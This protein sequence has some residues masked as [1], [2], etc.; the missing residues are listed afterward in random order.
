MFHGF[1][2]SFEGFP[3]Q[4]A[5]VFCKAILDNGGQIT[6]MLTKKTSHL[7]VNVEIHPGFQERRAKIQ[8]AW[9]VTES[10][11]FHSIK[12]GLVLP[13]FQFFPKRR[14]D[15]AAP[16]EG[17]E[18]QETDQLELNTFSND[19]ERL[20]EVIPELQQLLSGDSA[21]I[22]QVWGI[23]HVT[24]DTTTACFP[25][26][27]LLDGESPELIQNSSGIVKKNSTATLNTI[28]SKPLNKP[29]KRSKIKKISSR[30]QAIKNFRQSQ[31]NVISQVQDLEV[32]SQESDS[33]SSLSSEEAFIGVASNRKALFMISQSG[34]VWCKPDRVNQFPK[35]M[36]SSLFHAPVCMIDCGRAH[37]LAL[38]THGSVYSWGLGLSGQLGHADK[39]S[40]NTPERIRLVLGNIPVIQISAAGNS[41]AALTAIGGCYMWGS[42][43][44]GQLGLGHSTDVT[45][46]S[47][48]HFPSDCEQ[49]SS[50]ICG[51]A[52]SLAITND[53]KL[54]A[55]GDNQYGQLGIENLKQSV[56]NRPR[57]IPSLSGIVQAS[58]GFAH[59]L[60]VNHDGQVFSWG[61]GNSGVLG[62]GNFESYNKPKLIEFLSKSRVRVKSTQCSGKV[63]YCLS[64]TG[65]LFTFGELDST[66]DVLQISS[67]PKLTQDLVNVEFIYASDTQVNLIICD[68]KAMI[69]RHTIE[70]N[71]S[72]FKLVLEYFR[73]EFQ[74]Q[75]SRSFSQSSTWV[76]TMLEIKNGEGNSLLH[77]A[78]IHNRFEIVRILVQ[79]FG[80]GMLNELNNNSETA[81]YHCAL[82]HSD[83]SCEI[84]LDHPD[85]KIDLQ[86]NSGST[87]LHMAVENAGDSLSIVEMLVYQGADKYL[88]N[89]DG[90]TPLHLAVR[91]N[92]IHLARFLV[93][94]GASIME[95]NADGATPLDYCSWIERVVLKDLAEMN[96]VFISYAH[97]DMEFAVSVRKQL[98]NFCLRCWM[99]DWRLKPGDDW[100]SAIGEG[101][102]N[103][104]VVVFIASN[105]SVISDWC[106]KEL[107]LAVELSKKIVVIHQQDTFPQ[108]PMMD[109]LVKN[110][111]HQAKASDRFDCIN[112]SP[113]EFKNIMYQLARRLHNLLAGMKSS[114]NQK[115]KLK[116]SSSA[117]VVPPKAVGSRY[118]CFGYEECDSSFI[119]YLKSQLKFYRIDYHENM[120]SVDDEN[121]VSNAWVY[122][123]VVSRQIFSNPA[124]E[125]HLKWI[126]QANV[127]LMILYYDADSDYM[128]LFPT[129]M[130]SNSQISKLSKLFSF[131][132]SDAPWMKQLIYT[133]NLLEKQALLSY[134]IDALMEKVNK[135]RK[136]AQTL[137]NKISSLQRSSDNLPVVNF[138]SSY[139][140]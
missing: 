70:G 119:S 93:S 38:T 6:E 88:K 59:S 9:I 137:E 39:Q 27:L 97:V 116:N 23:T 67:L 33:N 17:E 15:L 69:Q 79:E 56:S 4:K 80:S 100:R 42:N 60:A 95:R 77:L 24:T 91:M 62:H 66:Q 112:T 44:T 14:A 107:F 58:V 110:V 37:T 104:D 21:L 71:L 135:N 83:E 113:E 11:I 5:S 90:M 86:N 123:L 47:L 41:S 84:L 103:A 29:R 129:S 19:E 54:L 52:H 74:T 12:A 81:L 65:K 94:Q 131:C 53:G 7:I 50:I 101:L 127:H 57:V 109:I 32:E 22:G 1:V 61:V 20:V 122:V 64:S 138:T 125:N 3:K 134:H 43:S 126:E 87:A 114:Q 106:L 48:V 118:I 28:A 46:P 117:I 31:E 75:N 10:F 133:L 45:L 108:T 68:P 49:I 139:V 25:R 111:L 98:N 115:E 13:E 30:N 51:S 55:W 26:Y 82:H 136:E 63:S 121:L 8:Q 120:P 128:N 89:S 18:I 132:V 73:S 124:L 102:L 76:N 78:C 85:T 16:L 140:F 34:Q 2:F 36:S 72:A 99:D 130:F 40:Y 105:S 35:P 96:Q 92:A